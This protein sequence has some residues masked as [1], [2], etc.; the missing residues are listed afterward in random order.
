MTEEIWNKVCHSE[1]MR[2]IRRLL[3]WK[4]G[5][6]MKKWLVEKF[7]PMWAKQIVLE[8]N[9]RLQK[10]NLDLK[11]ENRVLRSYIRGVHKVLR[12]TGGNA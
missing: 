3:K 8:D 6:V 10:E 4:M 1:R 9:R 11:Q 5:C 12:K 7:L 2:R